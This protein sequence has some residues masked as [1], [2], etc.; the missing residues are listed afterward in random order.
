MK[1]QRRGLKL[2]MRLR[3]DVIGALS[4]LNT[5]SDGV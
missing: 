4:L 3:R 1:R 5:H 2:P